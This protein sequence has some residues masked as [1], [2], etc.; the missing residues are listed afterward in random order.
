VASF[1]TQSPELRPIEALNIKL[2]KSAQ[3]ISAKKIQVKK[4]IMIKVQLFS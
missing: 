4:A 1:T 3:R 2:T